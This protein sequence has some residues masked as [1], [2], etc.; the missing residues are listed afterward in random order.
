MFAIVQKV[1]PG[2]RIVVHVDVIRVVPIVRPGIVH[3]EPES[4]ELESLIAAADK[5]RVEAEVVIAAKIRAEA[6]VGNAGT[7]ILVANTS[8]GSNGEIPAIVRSAS[9]RDLQ[10]LLRT[11]VALL[12]L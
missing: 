7:A 2:V 1:V 3:S 12:R 9:L 11:L 4:A 10:L 5:L 6:I 8:A